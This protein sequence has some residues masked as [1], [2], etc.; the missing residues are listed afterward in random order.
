MKNIKLDR[1]MSEN[2]TKAFQKERIVIVYGARQVGK[3]TASLD[4]F[5]RINGSKKLV[6][7]EDKFTQDELSKCTLLSIKNIIGDN[8][9]IFID[10]AQYIPSIGTILKMIYDNLPQVRVLATGSSAFGL[11]SKTSESMA[12]RKRSINAFS[13]TVEE[14]ENNNLFDYTQQA[15]DIV[16]SYG[17]YPK[18]L[19]ESD[20]EEKERELR[21]L[22]DSYLYKDVLAFQGINKPQM[23]AKLAQLLAFQIGNQI[24]QSEIARQLGI[25]K[26]TV[27]KYIDILEKSFIIFSLSAY[28][29]NKR[30]EVSRSKKYYF[31]DLGIR[32]AIIKNFQSLDTRDDVGRVWENYVIAEIYKKSLSQDKFYN[33]YFWR[34][35]GGQ[36]IDL[37][38]EKNGNLNVAEIKYKKTSANLPSDFAKDYKIKSIDIINKD[39]FFKF[40]E[41]F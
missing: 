2:I 3:T 13:L 10:E 40:I 4:Y 20:I 5:N 8:K 18:V 39:N 11:A 24:S 17:S 14:I 23:V 37:V 26:E 16:L 33:F 35:Y 31:W 25:S 29:T 38:L 32:N 9:F 30:N 28:S 7:G 21:D 34:N 15:L 22:A 27:E 41:N 19:L 6:N 1:L 36:E 12:G